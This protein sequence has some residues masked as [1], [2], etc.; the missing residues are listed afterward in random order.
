MTFICLAYESVLQLLFYSTVFKQ[1]DISLEILFKVPK[2]LP[3]E[4]NFV[5]KMWGLA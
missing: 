4:V 3:K 1:L 2:E 5:V